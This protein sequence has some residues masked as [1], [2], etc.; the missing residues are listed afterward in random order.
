MQ[1]DQHIYLS[2]FE[3]ISLV[4]CFSFLFSRSLHITKVLT[5]TKMGLLEVTVVK[6]RRLPNTQIMS[7]IDPYCKVKL[8][9]SPAFESKHISDTTE[10]VWNF[11]AKFQVADDSSEQI[12]IEVWN[13]NYVSDDFLGEYSMSMDGLQRG[14]P[15]ERWVLLQ[16]C[17]GNAELQVRLLA[18]DFGRLPSGAPPQPVPQAPTAPGYPPY[19]PPQP[20]A[21]PYPFGAP[22]PYAQPNVPPQ[23]YAPPMPYGGPAVPYQGEWNLHLLIHVYGGTTLGPIQNPR[24]SKL[25]M[26]YKSHVQRCVNF[27]PSIDLPHEKKGTLIFPFGDTKDLQDPGAHLGFSFGE[28]GYSETTAVEGGVLGRTFSRPEALALREVELPCHNHFISRYNHEYYCVIKKVTMV[29]AQ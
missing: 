21:Q 26:S 28:T 4:T 10:P 17:K 7:T 24:G 22:A 13:K 19:A 12:K 3:E 2:V 25:H 27:I 1:P 8:G 14:V 20:L 15:L 5:K 29:R 18:V 9:N 11:L 16:H 23:P 6:A